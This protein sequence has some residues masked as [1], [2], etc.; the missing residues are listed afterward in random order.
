MLL[1]LTNSQDATADYLTAE[2]KKKG[3]KYVRLDTDTLLSISSFSYGGCGP[4]LRI[5]G[6]WYAPEDFHATWYRRPERLRAHHLT[7]YPE[8]E[9]ILDEWSEALESFL[10]HISIDRWVN[11]PANN[12]RASSKLEQLTTAKQF[13]LMIPSTLVTQNADELRQFFTKHGG[14]VIVK[15]MASG[16]VRRESENADSLIYTNPIREADLSDLTD[17]RACPTFFQHLIPKVSDIRITIVDSDFHA[18]EL[19]AADPDGRQRCDIRRNNMNDVI[20]SAIDLPHDIECKLKKLMSRYGLR[21]GAIDMVV[22]RQGSWYFLEINPNGQ[23]A[24]LDLEGVTRI[25][26]SFAQSFSDRG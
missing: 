20:Y 17:L 22:D 9:Y 1:V 16:Q 26:D 12:S 21:F 13:D 5:Y 4:R 2:L 23:W 6:Q 25:A 7:G 14:Q 10:A 19:L 3:I 24:W 18:V 8:G 11:H 15:P